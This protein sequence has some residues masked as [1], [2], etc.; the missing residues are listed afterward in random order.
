MDIEYLII[1]MFASPV[2]TGHGI[3]KQG[4]LKVA[5]LD[6]L[7]IL[8]TLS[9]TILKSLNS[10]FHYNCGVQVETFVQIIFLLKYVNYFLKLLCTV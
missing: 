1:F 7:S 2:I 8:L 3:L 10:S 6:P 5:T 4:M 9:L